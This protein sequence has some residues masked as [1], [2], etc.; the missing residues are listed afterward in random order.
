MGL[1][2]LKINTVKYR[3]NDISQRSGHDHGESDD[4]TGM[5]FERIR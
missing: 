2:L 4:Q 5:C 1:L 3:I